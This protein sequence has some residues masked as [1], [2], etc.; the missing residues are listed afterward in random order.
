MIKNRKFLKFEL[1][2]EAQKLRKIKTDIKTKQRAGQYAGHEQ[3]ELLT[4]KWNYRHR[5]IAYCMMRGREYKQIERTCR[6][7]P[8]HDW[9]KEIINEYSP[10]KETIRAS[11]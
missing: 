6:V 11:A 7:E 2:L 4:L 10:Q 9:V 3:S 1:K 5:F 8:N